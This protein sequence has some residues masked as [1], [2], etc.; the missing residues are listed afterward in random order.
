VSGLLFVTVAGEDG[1][2]RILG[3]AGIGDGDIAEN[4]NGAARG[5]EAA[6]VEAIGAKTS[7]WGVMRLLLCIRHDTKDNALSRRDGC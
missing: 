3:E 5:F 6:S 2:A 4:E 7:P 1:E